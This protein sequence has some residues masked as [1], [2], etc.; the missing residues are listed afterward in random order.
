[1]STIYDYQGNPAPNG[2]V[3]Y[4]NAS[5]SG[6]VTEK[7]NI[8]MKSKTGYVLYEF[9]HY[10]VANKNCNIWRIGY[11]KKADKSFT[12]SELITTHGEWECAIMLEGR[13]DHS[14]GVLHGNE[15]FQTFSIFIDGVL[16]EKTAISGKVPFKS[17]QVIQTS[18]LYDKNDGTTIFAEHT[19][20]H[21]FEDKLRIKQ[22]VLF[23]GSYTL[24]KGYLSMFP[25]AK[26]HS[27]HYFTDQIYDYTA[28]VIPFSQDEAKS[29]TLFGGGTMATFTLIS[30]EGTSADAKGLNVRD[31]GEGAMYNKCY[32]NT[33]VAG[34]TVTADTIW[35]VETEY[36]IIA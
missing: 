6:G 32:F 34:D 9:S 24:E 18:N 14:G 1:M 28:T 19:S 31:S 16:T 26:T 27:T 36:D 11:A 5:E 25:I 15:V 2:F 22:S 33:A 29:I 21:K 20:L 7:L 12:A 35:Q 30:Q 17:L 10:V 8:Y 23:K 13:A 3:E 4:S